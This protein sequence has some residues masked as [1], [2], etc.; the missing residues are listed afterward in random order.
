MDQ[1]K[2]VLPGSGAL[3]NVQWWWVLGTGVGV[4]VF[5]CLLLFPVIVGYFLILSLLDR[6]VQSSVV[7]FGTAYGAWGMPTIHMLLVAFAAAWLAR[8]VGTAAVTHGVLAALVSVVVVQAIFSYVRPPFDLSE[9]A[10]YLVMATAGSLL[11]GLEGRSVLAGQEAFYRVSRDIS[12]ARDPQ[13]VLAAVHVYLAGSAT[14]GEALWQPPGQAEE[15]SPDGS[16][17]L[18]TW[19]PWFSR[20]W[21]DEVGFDG[22]DVLALAGSGRGSSWTLR[23]GRLSASERATWRQKGVRSVLLLPLVAPG[24]GIIGLL[25]VASRKKRIPR[26]TVRAC[27]T[28]GVQAALAL[29]NLR[30]LDE[31]RKAGRQAGV[32]RERQRMAHEIHDTLAQGFTS[33]VMNLEAAEGVIPSNLDRAQHHLD[34]ARL[35]ARESLTEARRLVW[36][37]RPEPLENVSLP[38]ALGRLAER[39]STESGISAGVS[40]TGTPC[41]LPSEVEAML[42]RVAQEALN[43]VR[44]HAR[45]AS[46]VALTLSYMGETATLDVRDDGAGFDPARES[47]KT[48]DRESGGFGLKGMRE[49]VEGVGGVLSVESA[50]GEGSTLTVELP[51]VRLASPSRAGS[52]RNAE[53]VT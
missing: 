9:A 37:L 23:P 32:L 49:R 5:S 53:E 10:T 43:N 39:W 38:E 28:I 40:T 7:Q 2:G 6:D 12:A 34:Q 3:G 27:L 24:G 52:S 41:P 21:P 26:S 20:H 25:A 36:A 18:D 13:D 48:R 11:G 51:V 19:R 1:R 29:E 47:G 15:D 17:G 31:A 4:G 33:I 8:K 35:T 44:K 42:F 50:P 30:L 22:L 46:R 45:E 16:E 14:I